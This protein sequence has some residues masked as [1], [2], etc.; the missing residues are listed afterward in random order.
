MTAEAAPRFHCE[1]LATGEELISGRTV[2]TNSA[3]IAQ[4]VASVGY[5]V[6]R[7]TAV[8]DDQDDIVRALA[9]ALSRTPLVIVT[10][11][12]GPTDDDRTRFAAARVFEKPIVTS[13]PS[14]AR[15]RAF[16]EARGREMPE[17][18]VRQAQFPE[19][20]EVWQNP[21][22]TADGFRCVGEAG[23]AVFLPGV[24][25]EQERMTEMYV[26]PWLSS[27]NPSTHVASRMLRVFGAAESEIGA[28][29]ADWPT[30]ESGVMLVYGANFPEIKLT[31]A[32]RADTQDEAERRV[33]KARDHLRF[34]LGDK[35]YSEDGR[36]LAETVA[37]FLTR[38]GK[39]VAT[40]ESCTGGMIAAAL[41]DIPGSSAYFVA[42]FVTYANAAKIRALGVSA[43]T[44]ETHGAVSEQTACQMAEGARARAGAD[45]AIAVTGIAGPGGG[46]S[47]KPVGTVHIALATPTETRAYVRKF[48]GRRDFIRKLAT[49]WAL[50]ILRREV[51]THL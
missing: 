3:H 42:G 6:R 41:T 12:L 48:P 1:I 22:G 27:H 50:D 18:N 17:I 49:F 31:L 40:A 36:D 51:I 45:F 37:D 47:E 39:T 26:L 9:D 10:G 28:K 19:G 30:P 2:D 24:P 5:L 35:I 33:A 15:L 4:R 7:I 13:N 21:V 16:W 11:G 8:G 46:S 23:E 20:A 43:E 25:V 44:L 38:T 14:L 34:V 29:L 32:A